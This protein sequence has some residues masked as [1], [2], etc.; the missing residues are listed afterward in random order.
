MIREQLR[1]QLETNTTQKHEW[2]QEL[3]RREQATELLREQLRA[4]LETN[5]SQ[6]HEWEQELSRREQATELL[7]EQL[8]AERTQAVAGL[9]RELADRVLD[10]RKT[11]S[12][13]L[14]TGSQRDWWSIVFSKLPSWNTYYPKHKWEQERSL[15]ERATELHRDQLQAERNDPG[16]NGAKLEGIERPKAMAA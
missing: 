1:A 15:R 7:R 13:R 8:L 2:E 14:W 9:K 12:S 5:T 4:Q 16:N 6:K 11:S 3:L 10:V